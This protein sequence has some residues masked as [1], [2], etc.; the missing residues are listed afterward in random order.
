VADFPSPALTILVLLR[1]RVAFAASAEGDPLFTVNRGPSGFDK[2]AI[3]TMHNYWDH[4][5]VQYE[6]FPSTSRAT[7]AVPS[8]RFLVVAFVRSGTSGRY[9]LSGQPNGVVTASHNVVYGRNWFS[10]GKDYRDG[11]KQFDGSIKRFIVLS[12]AMTA[13]EIA[14]VSAT[15]V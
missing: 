9:Y 2:E 5:L 7:T 8:D 10:I 6:G 15:L 11:G 12:Y 4:D 14:T 3:M 13:T 1:P